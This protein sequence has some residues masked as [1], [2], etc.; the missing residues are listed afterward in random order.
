M[1]DGWRVIVTGAGGFVGRHIVDALCQQ[2]TSVLAIDRAFDADLRVRWQQ[3]DRIQV[4]EADALEHLQPADALIHAAA[5]T[6]MPDENS[7][8]A[9]KHLK[10]NLLPTLDLLEWG[11]SAGLQRMIFVSSDAV[12]STSP[13]GAIDETQPSHALGTYAVAKAATEQI[14]E[15]LKFVHGRDVLT[16]RLSGIYG[17]GEHVRPTR[18]RVSSVLGFVEMAISTGRITVNGLR[19]ARSWTYAAD[20]GNAVCALLKQPRLEHARYNVATEE[21]LTEEQIALAIQA[22]LPD[23]TIDVAEATDEPILRRGHLTSAR[24]RQETG[25]ENWT[26]FHEGIGRVIAWHR[27]QYSITQ[28]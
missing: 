1:I 9:E 28:N 14:V 17:T 11:H 5:I 6:T 22:Y 19:P 23:V 18:P 21:C 13:A 4:I 10:D 8:P 3:N 15:T 2:G 7:Y 25:F 12:H 16:V 26:S 24:L 20:I 27:E